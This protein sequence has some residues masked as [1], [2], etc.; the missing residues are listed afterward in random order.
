MTFLYFFM[1][2]IQSNKNIQ[3]NKN[4]FLS[5]YFLNVIKYFEPR[6]HFFIA[7][8]LKNNNFEIINT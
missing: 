3:T 4:N 1:N 2:I 5:I 6:T 7:N 8:N